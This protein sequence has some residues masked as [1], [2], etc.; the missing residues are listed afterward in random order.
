MP[1]KREC[2]HPCCGSVC[3]KKKAKKLRKRLNPISKKQAKRNREYSKERKRFLTE[4]DLCEAG[5]EGCTGLA[6][7]LH[8]PRGRLGDRLTDIK[9]C[10]K[11]CR[12]CHDK[13]ERAPGMAKEL[14]LSESRLI[15]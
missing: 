15:K 10:K 14:G 6:T 3:R 2:R 4:G 11:V 12:D 13:I 1:G 5:L 7:E 9:K 8:H